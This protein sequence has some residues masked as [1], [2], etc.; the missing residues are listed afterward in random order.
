MYDGFAVSKKVALGA[1][2]HREHIVIK[3]EEMLV[4]TLYT[5]QIHLQRITV[6]RRKILFRHEVFVMHHLYVVAINP[7][8]NLGVAGHYQIN[9]S[10]ASMFLH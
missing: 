4:Q 3:V 7:F 2:K 1:R 6:E 10:Y 9:V 8:R 5:M